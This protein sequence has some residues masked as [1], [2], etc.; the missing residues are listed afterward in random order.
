MYA[1]LWLTSVRLH[2]ASLGDT[3]R[4]E[5]RAALGACGEQRGWPW[6]PQRVPGQSLLVTPGFHV[7]R[8]AC[9]PERIYGLQARA[10]GVFLV[11]RGHRQAGRTLQLPVCVF[12]A[13]GGWSSAR[14]PACSPTADTWSVQSGEFRWGFF[15]H[16]FVLFTGDVAVPSGPCALFPGAV[17]IPQAGRP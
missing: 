2:P 15:L 5:T 10:R 17:S 7:C 11:V 8:R 16:S 3:W 14:L 4:T 9:S 6:R 1:G 13:A 12:P